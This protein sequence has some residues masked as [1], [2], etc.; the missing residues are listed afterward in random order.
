MAFDV[1]KAF[2]KTPIRQDQA[3]IVAEIGV[4]S[5][6][7]DGDLEENELGALVAAVALV[8]GLE[9]WGVPQLETLITEMNGKYAGEGQAAARV[10]EIVGALTDPGL[11]RCAYQLAAICAAADGEFS[12]SES[13]FL[14]GLQLHFEIPDPDAEALVNEAVAA[15]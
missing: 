11:R 4:W 10:V 1:A 2:K 13:E 12:D 14:Q 9:N 6:L 8:P 15:L 5:A 3:Q 7:S